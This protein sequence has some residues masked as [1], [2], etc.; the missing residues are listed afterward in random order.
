MSSRFKESLGFIKNMRTEDVYRTKDEDVFNEKFVEEPSLKM[1]LPVNHEQF[2]E[3]YPYLPN[4]FCNGFYDSLYPSFLFIYEIEGVLDEIQ[5]DGISFT[6]AESLM[7]LCSLLSVTSTDAMIDIDYEFC[8]AK[9][10][11]LAR[12]VYVMAKNMY[13]A[14]MRVHTVIDR[15]L[16]LDEP[17]TLTKYDEIESRLRCE[18]IRSGIAVLKLFHIFALLQTSPLYSDGVHQIAKKLIQS[19]RE[20]LYDKRIIKVIVDSDVYGGSTKAHKT[21]RLKIYFAMGNSDR[22]CIRL[23]FPHVGEDS[24]HLN[25]NEPGRK[26]STGFPFTRDV[27]DKAFRLCGSKG[28]FDSLFYYRD[29]LYWFRHD[30]AENVNTLG[31]ENPEQGQALEE[32][33]HR[34][35][36]SKP[37]VV[38]RL[39]KL[40]SDYKVTSPNNESKVIMCFDCDD[41][42]RKQE[43]KEF[44]SDAKTFCQDNGYD[45]V[46]FCREI[47]SV[48]LGR[49]VPD[50]QKH[51]EAL[52]FTKMN[53]IRD[54]ELRNLKVSE[55]QDKR[56]N[57]CCVLDSYLSLR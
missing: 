32:F 17:V 49:T 1:E 8:F 7:D 14:M 21:T 10:Y 34:G 40:K 37:K 38:K 20:V 51:K 15:D 54:I 39:A 48:Y 47:E 30:F 41:Y 46:W 44:L 56:S 23:D 2:A 36:Y 26:Q 29:D 24:I 52:N 11:S 25:M 53:L 19:L 13:E 5:Y 50:N 18:Y 4:P 16:Q 28:V 9:K 12:D 35:N 43:D 6:R 33:H 42:D 3:E 27:H 22:Y 57:L 45:F 55:Y 31:K